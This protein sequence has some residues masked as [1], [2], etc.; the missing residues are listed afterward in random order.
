[1][2]LVGKLADFLIVNHSKHFSRLT[3][4]RICNS[5]GLGLQTVWLLGLAFGVEGDGGGEVGGG[6]GGVENGEVNNSIVGGDNVALISDV[7]PT[8]PPSY[9]PSATLAVALLVCATGS[10]SFCIGGYM[11][12]AMD[13]APDFAGVI[14]GFSN[15][16][17]RSR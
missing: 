1:M 7:T 15:R 5:L 6:R 11:V 4:R 10:W 12:N 9:S 8:S 14:L 2:L 17:T 13:I 3:V 16:L